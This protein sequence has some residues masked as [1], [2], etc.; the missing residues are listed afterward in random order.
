MSKFKTKNS[1]APEPVVVVPARTGVEL[2]TE[3]AGVRQVDAST[4]M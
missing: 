4:I 2:E 3:V 1:E